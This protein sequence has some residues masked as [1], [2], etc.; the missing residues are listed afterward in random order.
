MTETDKARRY[1]QARVFI[2]HGLIP[3]QLQIR[4]IINKEAY[5][6]PAPP[7]T[8]IQKGTS[9]KK[10][11]QLSPSIEAI[12]QWKQTLRKRLRALIES[13]DPENK[14]A[15]K[16]V[17]EYYSKLFRSEQD[18]T[19]LP[20]PES[21]ESTLPDAFASL[22]PLMT[23]DKVTKSLVSYGLQ[24]S[25]GPDAI[26]ARYMRILL[27]CGLA[28]LLS[29][30]FQ[31][32]I[33]SSLTPAR[34]NTCSVTLLA[35]KEESKTVDEFR[36]ISL[37]MMNR[38]LFERCLLPW[39]ERR[40]WAK[41]SRIQ[42]GF[43]RN[44]STISA[45]IMLDESMK[46]KCRIMVLLDFAQ[47]Y[48]SV[49][50][51]ELLKRL[52]TRGAA[53]QEL[54]LI[55]SLMIK[56]RSAAFV[57]NQTVLAPISLRRGLQQGSVLSPLLFNVY[58]D[59]LAERLDQCDAAIPTSFLYA[60]DVA[61]GEQNPSAVQQ[62]I[63]IVE[64]WCE[65][66]DT[67]IKIPKCIVLGLR[68]D[69][70]DITVNGQPLPRNLPTSEPKYVGYDVDNSGIRWD[71]TGARLSRKAQNLLTAMSDTAMKWLP[72]TRV[73]VAKMCARSVTDY[74]AGPLHV[75]VS[76][77]YTRRQQYLQPLIDTHNATLR[78]C[79][80]TQSVQGARVLESLFNLVPPE[81]RCL[82]LRASIHFQLQKLDPNHPI[83]N[84]ARGQQRPDSILFTLLRGD[85]DPLVQDYNNVNIQRAQQRLPQIGF[86]CY[87]QDKRRQTA[88]TGKLA[89]MILPIA[90]IGSAS[91]LDGSLFWNHKSANTAIAWRRG[92][93]LQGRECVCGLPFTRRHIDSSCAEIGQWQQFLAPLPEIREHQSW[94]PSET[95]AASYTSLD[96][97]LNQCDRKA[98]M[99]LF[100][101]LDE[102]LSL[103]AT[104]PRKKRKTAPS[105]QQD[106]LSIINSLTNFH[107]H[108]FAAAKRALDNTP[109]ATPF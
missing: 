12:R 99:A 2:D 65:E 3:P 91:W 82:E 93:A 5:L 68:P 52:H 62:K 77:D 105:L 46:R 38:R 53:K 4:M 6:T 72:A 67:E 1:R 31:L 75:W 64:T 59:S 7:G 49:N 54:K 16:D 70:P 11:P 19:P 84:I 56:D 47:A 24:K 21:T 108:L 95:I 81:Q 63:N 80:Q 36:P 55:H 22:L 32:C 18:E 14:S 83:I 88:G 60:D 78:F 85:R 29:R 90:R 98:F 15:A 97:W 23:E 37:T 106:Q 17:L 42:S 69:E 43:R 94:L 8:T 39:L 79:A 34:W 25:C 51:G 57:V 26:H 33:K 66:S 74:V 102:Q 45:A 27:P 73:M 96:Y 20:N 13:R 50:H 76:L 101:Q 9:K 71:K 58:I 28:S 35:K 41:C 61:T 48:D 107:Q 30:L 40:P 89:Q 86:R 109:L 44:R 10:S 104:Q 103:P 92:V 87:L 100:L